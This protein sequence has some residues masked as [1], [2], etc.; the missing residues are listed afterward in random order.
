M[1]LESACLTNFRCYRNEPI[2]FAPYT[3]ILGPNNSGKSTIFKA[4]D[5]FFRTTQKS[6]PIVLSDFS[7]PGKELRIALTFSDLPKK[8]IE[9]FAHYYRHEKLEFFI[10]AKTSDSGNVT[11]SVHGQRLGIKAFGGFFEAGGANEKK[12]FY[13]K[14]RES[15]SDLPDIPQRNSVAVF[16]SA[17]QEFEK[18]HADRHEVIESED[19]AFGAAGVAAKLRKYVDW[20]Y[21][22][23]VKDAADED[24]E[25]KNTAFGT[26]INR[27]IRAR[28]KVDEKIAAIQAVAHDQIKT[29]VDDY[30]DEISKLERVLDTEFRKIT[31]TDAHVHLDWTEIGPNSV[32]LNPPLVRSILSD[33]TFKGDI[34]N[35]GHGLQ[36]NYLMTLVHL[37]SKFAIEDQPS[38][39]LACEEPELYQHPP[40]ARYLHTALQKIS[41]TD[42]VLVTTHSPY[43]VSARTF[44]KI[45]VVRKSPHDLSKVNFWT[46][47]EH[48]KLIAKAKGEEAIGEEAALAK[49]DLFIQPELNESFFCGK[50]ILVEGLEDRAVLITALEHSNL[51]NEFVRYGGHVVGVNGK[52]NLI[53]M[54]AMARGFGTPHF[55][56]FDADKNCD[57]GQVQANKKQNLTL[58]S[59]LDLSKDE[60]VWPEHDMITDRAVIW[61]D[62]IQRAIA[63]QYSG[64]FDDVKGVCSQ[65]GWE[66]KRLDKNPA[67]IAHALENALRSG[68]SITCLDEL[69]AKVMQFT[70]GN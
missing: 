68:V 16:E 29:L 22:P 13:G 50:L 54:I 41:E 34:S 23:A 21:I 1:K 56:M 38:I 65:W 24:E 57:V 8:A 12:A 59:L 55:V 18:L 31:S 27:I 51:F 14:L 20:V 19:L 32:S 58:V 39:I 45:R 33:D 66:Y 61:K 70:Q 40:Q 64:W 36:R 3:A 67:V 46:V 42:Q 28:V 10:R 44:E 43:F 30:K 15:F 37:N 47:D 26:L 25:A 4:I 63:Q 35:F 7:E 9:E 69:V 53:N 52:G 11:A 60:C 5:L 48:R 17:L 49:L 2:H 6:S 62:N